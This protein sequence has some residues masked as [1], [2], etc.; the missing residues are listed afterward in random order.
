MVRIGAVY[1]TQ[2]LSSIKTKKVLSPL[3]STCSSRDAFF[4]GGFSFVRMHARAASPVC[5]FVCLYVCFLYHCRRVDLSLIPC[6][7]FLF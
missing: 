6:L 2:I 7:L 4:L 5:L 1:L 3:A